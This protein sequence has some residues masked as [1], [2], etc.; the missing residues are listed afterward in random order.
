LTPG[1]AVALAKLVVPYG[2]LLCGRVA[3]V[4]TVIIN[5]ASGYFG[6]DGVMVALAMG[7]ARVVAAGGDAEQL[8]K[9]ATILGP[10]V[11]PAALRALRRG[12]RLILMAVRLY[13]SRSRSARCWRTIGR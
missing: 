13:R 5:G 7:V 9:L 8:R 6:S 10:R 3:S 4:D 2:G 11:V 12:G 1:C